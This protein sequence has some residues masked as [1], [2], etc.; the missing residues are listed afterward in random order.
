VQPYNDVANPE[1]NALTRMAAVLSA[2]NHRFAYGLK[3]S[4]GLNVPLSA[5]MCVGADLLERHGWPVF[6]IG[7]DLEFYAFLTERGT[8]IEAATGARLFAQE[9]Q[10]LQ[11][12]AS[13]RKRWTGGKLTVL[14]RYSWRLLLSRRIGP[15]QKLDILAE[16]SSLGPAVHLGVVL[17][18]IAVAG[19]TPPPGGIGI[20]VALVASLIRP[21]IYAAA[22]IAA[23]PKP[24][25]ALFAFCYLPLYTVWR[26]GT[27]VSALSM[28]GEKPWVQTR[29]HAPA[30][31]HDGRSTSSR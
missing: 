3:N 2:A 4:A 28:I 14:A 20:A 16:L 21:A 31:D 25:E 5:G 9:A 29:R 15:A 19:L 6:T 22:A 18:A 17:T 11:Q 12:S 24:V 13:Q 1:D 10:S 27:A 23:D 30:P 8:R 26:L 7:E